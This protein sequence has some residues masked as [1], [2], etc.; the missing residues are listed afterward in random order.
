MGRFES[1]IVGT[2]IAVLV[3]SRCFFAAW[4]LCVG[5]A[6]VAVGWP[7]LVL[8]QYRL[9]IKAASAASGGRSHGAQ[10]A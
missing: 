8:C 2:F 3:P 10:T 6:L 5:A 1:R 7:A 9:A 4:R